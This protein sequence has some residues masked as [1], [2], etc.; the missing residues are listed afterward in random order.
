[1]EI[2]NW[3]WDAFVHSLSRL[4]WSHIGIAIAIFSVFLLFRKIFTTYIFKIV[5]AMLRKTPTELFTNILLSFERPI[6]TFWIVLGT[7]LALVYLPFHFT[8]ISFVDDL[9][10]SIIII[11]IGWGLYNYTSAHSVAFFRFMRD[12]EIDAHSMLIPFVSKI[13]RFVIVALT[14]VVIASEWGYEISGFIAGLGLGGLAF[15]LAA[16][17]TIGNFF[18]GI[19]IITEKPFKKGD[20]IQTPSVE[21]TVEDINFRSTQIRTFADSVVTIPNSTLANEPIT[22]WSEMGKRRVSFSIGLMYSTPQEKVEK[23]ARRIEEILRSHD[24]IDQELIMVRF[25]EFNSS[26]LDIFVYFFTKTIA[27]TEWFRIKE[28]INFKVM[29]ILEEENVTI[30]FPSRSIY[31]ENKQAEEL[32]QEYNENSNSA[33]NFSNN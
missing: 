16:Q 28:D 2:N 12:S 5:L 4:E 18:G 27:W 3:K 13:L 32:S 21:G 23:C 19:I 14:I 24:E 6:R 33:A 8:T 15:A 17:D 20:W 22:N 9:Y 26:S 25:N 31:L 30:A 1:M 29:K 11:L 10:R 7:Y